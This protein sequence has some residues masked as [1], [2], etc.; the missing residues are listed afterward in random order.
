MERSGSGKA[1]AKALQGP[2]EV[3][4]A[5]FHAASSLTH[6]VSEL[7]RFRTATILY[8]ILSGERLRLRKDTAPLEPSLVYHLVRVPQST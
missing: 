8:E 2:S 1:R 7:S 4:T 6:T 5:C 3:H